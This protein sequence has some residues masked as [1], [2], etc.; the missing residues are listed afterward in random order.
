MHL[1][2][3]LRLQQAWEVALEELDL[4]LRAPQ[5]LLHVADCPLQP[6]QVRIA[7]AEHHLLPGVEPLAVLEEL[8]GLVQN[9]PSVV[10]LPKPHVGNAQ[11]RPS[12]HNPEEEFR[13]ARAQV[14]HELHARLCQ[15]QDLVE[16]SADLEAMR[17]PL[18]LKHQ[19][20]RLHQVPAV[21]KLLAPSPLCCEVL[22][23]GEQPVPHMLE[24]TW[25]AGLPG[26]DIHGAALRVQADLGGQ[27]NRPPAEARE[28]AHRHV[29]GVRRERSL[30]H[31]AERAE[32]ASDAD[33]RIRGGG[34]TN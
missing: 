18:G 26:L 31:A 27:E 24:K 14:V 5:C 1:M 28:V 25:V 16:L 2:V 13:L 15:V 34:A 21:D 12:E 22:N 33:G 30:L 11:G 23:G 4:Q 29:L 10:I 19:V 9:I 32:E 8:N 17:R 3:L 7:G 20:Q 6:P